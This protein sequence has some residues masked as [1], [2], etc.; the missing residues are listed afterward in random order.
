MT[1]GQVLFLVI[2]L[3]L[4]IYITLIK[5]LDK[6]SKLDFVINMFRIIILWTIAFTSTMAALDTNK[7]LKEKCPEYEQVN[8]VFY[9][10]K[11][12]G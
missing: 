1:V 7:R 5:P 10:L 12:P 9:K 3:A 2:L 6:G 4:D 11:Q 8:E